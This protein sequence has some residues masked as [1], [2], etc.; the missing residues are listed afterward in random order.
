MR[1]IELMSNEEI[2]TE[3]EQIKREYRDLSKIIIPTQKEETSRGSK[4][5]T[6]FKNLDPIIKVEADDELLKRF[7]K[8]FEH[9]QE[10]Y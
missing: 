2:A 1:Y 8:E 3:I 10:G 4:V 5:V 9:E 6:L 7:I